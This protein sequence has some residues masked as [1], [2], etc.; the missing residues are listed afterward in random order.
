ML[1]LFCF[2]IHKELFS[3]SQILQWWVE[4]HEQE[5]GSTSE[6]CP[7]TLAAPSVEEFRAF[8]WALYATYVI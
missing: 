8:L 2:Q 4:D 1:P 7:L 5:H 3:C 6:F